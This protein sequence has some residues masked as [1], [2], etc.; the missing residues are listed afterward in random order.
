MVGRSRHSLILSIYFNTRGFAFV[1]FE[2]YLAPFDWGLCE[3]RGPRKHRR[4]LARVV[5]ILDRYKP[6]ALVIRDTSTRQTRTPRLENLTA[7]VREMANGRHIPVYSYS[8]D[9]VRDAF[10]YTGVVDKQNLAELIAKHIP[11]FE[12]YVPPPRKLWM[13]EDRRMGLFD[14]VALALVF[15]QKKGFK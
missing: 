9:H 12:R 4:C 7:A 10:K 3:M 1:F 2:G 6:D 14:A 11:T 15:F 8:R 5:K 13:S